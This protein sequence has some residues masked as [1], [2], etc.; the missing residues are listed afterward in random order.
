MTVALSAKPAK[1]ALWMTNIGNLGL[2]M[3]VL[4]IVAAIVYLG[5]KTPLEMR[6][7]WLVTMGLM[8]VILGVIGRASAGRTWA[9]LIDDRNKYSLSRLQLVLWT[10]V[11]LSAFFTIALRRLGAAGVEPLAIAIPE[12]LWWLMGIST[13]TL[14]GTPLLRSYK[15][16]RDPL[17]S[18]R[19]ETLNT[20]RA[21]SAARGQPQPETNGL[22]VKNLST[23]DARWTDLF[24]GE[25][26]GNATL[27]DMGKIQMFFFTVILLITYALALRHTFTGTELPAALPAIDGSMIALL[28][29]SHAGYLANKAVPHSTEA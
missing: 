29:I 1:P 7:Q 24:M 27:P 17:P 8:A 5:L 20:L 15:A 16:L 4:L 13:T 3:V 25:E 19:A 6:T 28:G 2:G 21:R 11:G 9:T 22:I 18:E 10:L 12:E 26:T 23:N 14:V